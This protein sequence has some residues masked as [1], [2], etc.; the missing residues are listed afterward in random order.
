MK[1]LYISE[2][3]LCKQPVPIAIE[4]AI[5]HFLRTQKADLGK[6]LQITK[7]KNTT[8][9]PWRKQFR[10]IKKVLQIIDLQ[11]FQWSVGESNP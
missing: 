3:P 2:R 1:T 8:C 7:P 10:N 9:P 5:P 6:K 11:H 4:I